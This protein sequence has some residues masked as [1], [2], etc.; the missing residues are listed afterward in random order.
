MAEKGWYFQKEFLE[1][2]LL[3]RSRTA[4]GGFGKKEWSGFFEACGEKKDPPPKGSAT[5]PRKQPVGR[6]EQEGLQKR[7]KKKVHSPRKRDRA[8]EESR[9]RKRGGEGKKPS[10]DCHKENHQHEESLN[11]G[12]RYQ[13][14]LRRIE[15]DL[16]NKEA[17]G[18]GQTV[19]GAERTGIGGKKTRL[20]R[21]KESS[22]TEN[23][24]AQ[25]RGKRKPSS[26]GPGNDRNRWGELS[27]VLRA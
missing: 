9:R 1:N 8:A 18:E 27:I 15:D 25:Q 4:R 20:S 16:V 23:R 2:I 11:S 22:T 24:P 17:W 13:I 26:G 21:N 5:P 19:V 3:E 6:E 7:K 12:K 10:K 14:T